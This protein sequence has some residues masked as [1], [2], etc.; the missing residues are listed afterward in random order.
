[1][2]VTLTGALGTLYL[3]GTP[4]SVFG[5][6]GLITLVGL[7]SKHGILIVEFANRRQEEGLSRLD[8]I[9]E[10]ATMRLRPILMTSAATVLGAIPL[11]IASGAGAISRVH[12][13][14]AIVG[15]LTFGS[16]ITIFLVPAVYSLIGQ[17]HVRKIDAPA[18]VVAANLGHAP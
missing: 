11:A 2:P 3:T 8:A 12:I 16:L 6:I 15:G 14:L 10:A 17:R 18:P 1:V 4:L 13:G 5:E 7:I 9:R